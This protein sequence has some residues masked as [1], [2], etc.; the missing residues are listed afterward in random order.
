MVTSDLEEEEL[1]TIEETEEEEATL[2]PTEVQLIQQELE[3]ETKRH[4]DTV[5]YFSQRIKEE[6]E[7]HHQKQRELEAK[8]LIAIGRQEGNEADCSYWLNNRPI[9]TRVKPKKLTAAEKKQIRSQVK[10]TYSTSKK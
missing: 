1:E 4:D 6:T 2:E 3:K 10:K 5:A 7:R 8:L 9:A